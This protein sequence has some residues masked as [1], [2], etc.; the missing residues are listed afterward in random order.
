MIL[1]VVLDIDKVTF[2]HFSKWVYI[3]DKVGS[4]YD[5]YSGKIPLH[6]SG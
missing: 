4:R 3:S 1:I 6:P 2:M 5:L